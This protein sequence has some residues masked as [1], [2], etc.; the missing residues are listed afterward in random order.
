MNHAHYEAKKDVADLLQIIGYSD[1]SWGND[2][3]ASFQDSL[4]TLKIWVF[5]ANPDQNEF[6]VPSR[7]VVCDGG[8]AGSD[9]FDTNNI[10]VLIKYLQE[11]K[12]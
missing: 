2:T 10:T 7:F 3:T 8:D 11:Q 9:L 4:E 5:S 6:E 1:I 12:T